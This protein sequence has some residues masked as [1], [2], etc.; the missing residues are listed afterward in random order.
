[1]TPRLSQ[2]AVGVAVLDLAAGRRVPILDGPALDALDDALDS[3]ERRGARSVV[4]TGGGTGTFAAGADLAELSALD[5]MTAFRFAARG[6]A[7]LDRM[8]A[9]PFVLIAAIR[10]RCLG[11]ALDLVMAC[12]VRLS[13]SGAVFSHPGPRLGFITGYGGTSRLPLLAGRASVDV[14]MGGRTLDAG[15]ALALG[16]LAEVTEPCH[17]ED[18][19]MRLALSMRDVPA[20]RIVLVKEAL[21]RLSGSTS[22][23][24]LERRLSRLH[25]MAEA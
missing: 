6:Q 9:A 21:R 12:D 23:R 11:G 13:D 7:L 17:L 19:A 3:L 1:V 16:L 4:V 24:R 18:R 25:A 2:S 8:E 22:R 15:E 5:A 14:L 20:A 10:G